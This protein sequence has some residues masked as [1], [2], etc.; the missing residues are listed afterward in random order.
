MSNFGSGQTKIDCGISRQMSEFFTLYW[1][2]TVVVA[3]LIIN[4]ASAYLKPPL[5]TLLGS[6][7]SRWKARVERNKAAHN[8]LVEK[9]LA[10]PVLILL[11]GT[12]QTRLFL[13]SVLF[14]VLSVLLLL[15][16]AFLHTLDPNPKILPRLVLLVAMAVTCTVSLFIG[17][18][19]HLLTIKQQLLL[20]AV[21]KRRLTDSDP[22][23]Q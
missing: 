3:G 10:D 1:W 12:E 6:F 15:L 21:Q 19:C 5:D 8:A 23:P 7:S 4:L 16:T 14:L 11:A 13:Q 2:M 22:R 20:R 17:L 9:H 18:F